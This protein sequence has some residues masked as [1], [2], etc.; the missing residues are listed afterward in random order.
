[1]RCVFDHFFLAS[2]SVS[3]TSVNAALAPVG[4]LSRID[5]VRQ[6]VDMATVRL[7]YRFGEPPVSGGPLVAKY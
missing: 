5:N 6:E 4:S 7:N 2:R 1:V 3:F